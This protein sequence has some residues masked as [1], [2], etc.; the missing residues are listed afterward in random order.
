MEFTL[1]DFLILFAQRLFDFLLPG[2][3]V[4][5]G[6]LGMIEVAFNRYNVIAFSYTFAFSIW[7]IGGLST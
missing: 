2:N 5:W 6:G 4:F 3:I 7:V 1:R